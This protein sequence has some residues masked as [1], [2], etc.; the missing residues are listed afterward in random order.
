MTYDPGQ[1][2][3]LENSFS[4]AEEIVKCVGEYQPDKN[5]YNFYVMEGD[6]GEMIQGGIMR[7]STRF[8]IRIAGPAM[9]VAETFTLIDGKEVQVQSYRFTRS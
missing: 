1:G 7:S 3:F 4:T 6:G 2:F 8:E 5:A 9:F